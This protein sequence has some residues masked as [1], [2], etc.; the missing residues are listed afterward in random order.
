[1]VI[2]AVSIEI[3]RGI[4]PTLKTIPIGFAKTKCY[5]CEKNLW[6]CSHCL[7]LY[8]NCY[9]VCPFGLCLRFFNTW[10]NPKIVRTSCKPTNSKVMKNEAYSS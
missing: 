1:M 6:V 2:N 7:E 3:M 9:I 10:S 8:P 5:F 4:T